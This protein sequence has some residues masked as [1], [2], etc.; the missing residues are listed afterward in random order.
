[1]SDAQLWTDFVVYAT[2][3]LVQN[4]HQVRRC[5]GL[6]T[7]EELWRRPNQHANSVANLLLH[8]NGN[9]RQWIVAGLGGQPFDRDRP[10]EFAA[11]GPRPGDQALHNLEQT[12]A[13]ALRIIAALPVEQAGLSRTIQGYEV[14]TLTAVFHV[15]EH[16]SFHTGQIVH[17]T[18]LIKD[19][20]LSLYDGQGRKYSHQDQKHPGA[21]LSP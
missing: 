4:L 20:D 18:K 2:A 15:V 11:R 5:A 12:I 21:S 1:M 14:S 6:L 7:D 17:A 13:A 16:F 10:A 9:V 19:V 3:K 8:L